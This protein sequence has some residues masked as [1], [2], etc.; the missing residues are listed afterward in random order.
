MT[1]VDPGARTPVNIEV[2]FPGKGFNADDLPEWKPPA[3]AAEQFNPDELP[4]WSPKQKA[5]QREVGTAE[6]VG[7]GAVEGASFGFAPA[8]AGLR[9]AAGKDVRDFADKNLPLP[10]ALGV[11][12]TVGAARLLADAI[13]AHS[14]PEVRA[15][16]ERGR[17][18]ALENQQA[19]QEQHP[20]AYFAGQLGG[21]AAVPL[22]GLTAA[23]TG[24]RLVRGATIGGIGGAALGTGEAVSEGEDLP[25]IAGRAATGAALGGVLGGATGAIVGPR[26]RTG[27]SPGER[28]AQTAESLGAPL[29]RGV[30]S[31][32]A[33]IQAATAKA[34]SVPLVG[35]RI[36]SALDRTQEAAGERLGDIAVHT[37]GGIATDRATADAVVRP[38]LQQVIDNN[39]TAIDRAYGTVR[40]MISPTQRYTMPRTDA[41]LNRIMAARKAAGWTNPA[42]GLEQF[43]NVAGGAT[44]EGAHRARVDAREAGNVLVPHPGYNKGDYNQIVKAMTADIR[45]MARASGG[46]SA[47]NA[48]DTAEREFGRLAEQNRI[49]HNL[50]NAKGEGAIS[51]LLKAAS[52][53]G[54][55]LKLLAQLRATMRPDE[56]G[57]VSATLLNELGHSS[58]TGTFSLAQ[59]VTGWDKISDGAKRILFS[60]SHLRD[61]E[62]IVGM[63][64]HIKGALRESNTSHTAGVLIM[65]DLARDAVLLGASIGAGAVSGAA[66]P[67]MMAGG[68]ATVFAHWL[69]SPAKAASMGAWTRAYRGIT[70]GQPTPARLAVFNIATR[71]LANNLGIPVR[72]IASHVS[73]VPVKASDEQPSPPGPI[74]TH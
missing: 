27:T 73:G 35:S 52:E 31:D 55:N 67:G 53:K 25:G 71:N 1:F 50:V 15:S 3:K 34:R 32:N 65:F 16:Y 45:D 54:G 66:V 60:P 43:R 33:A 7:Q 68:A 21:A 23:T 49:L 30:A 44:F 36:S 63:G 70:L 64:Q 5:P 29:P 58:R 69:A 6:A 14:D 9:E 17:K 28:A 42:Q 19:A 18:A 26:L 20:W 38:G 57:Q 47:V 74:D 8:M 46:P 41:V 48:F 56:F 72:N 37:A 2:R 4:E 40:G 62:D 13:G 10:I 12:H 22:P 61:V 59:F 51:T 11:K 24:A 39:R